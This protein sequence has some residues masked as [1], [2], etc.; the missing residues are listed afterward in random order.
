[1]FMWRFHI[2]FCQQLRLQLC[3]QNPIHLLNELWEIANI[4]HAALFL[5]NGT[6]N[7]DTV[8]NK[9]VS[10]F[11]TFGKKYQYLIKYKDSD[12]ENICQDGVI[13]RDQDD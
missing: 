13:S 7:S 9:T 3:I 11:C 2:N 5:L 6:G 8:T 4:E 10:M 12:P 1:M